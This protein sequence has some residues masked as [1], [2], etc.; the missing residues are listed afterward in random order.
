[1]VFYVIHIPPAI[2][3]LDVGL[4]TG[5]VA[6]PLLSGLQGVVQHSLPESTVD[7]F[8]MENIYSRAALEG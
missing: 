4:C 3:R 8:L 5:W 7:I 2:E 1:M 6:S